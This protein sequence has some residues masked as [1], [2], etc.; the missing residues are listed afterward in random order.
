MNSNKLKR[1]LMLRRM[2]SNSLSLRITHKSPLWVRLTLVFIGLALAAAAGTW[3]Y[4]QGASFAGFNK[5]SIY[6][7]LE[8]LRSE[9]KALLEQREHLNRTSTS[10]QVNLD[11]EKATA[12][13]V[14]VQNQTLEAENAKL[15]EDLRFFET[16]LPTAG[17][18]NTL[19]VRNLQGQLNVTNNQL[20]VRLLVMQSG[21]HV[22]SFVGTLQVNATGIND[23]KPFTWTYPNV[24]AS[25]TADTQLNFLRYQRVELSIPLASFG[26]TL[27]KDAILKSLNIRVVS[28]GALKAQAIGS[29]VQNV[30]GLETTP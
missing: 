25:S 19:S 12:K 18:A 23:G 3:L 30:Q 7:E 28:G 1:K 16:L 9:N 2:R 27:R 14:L 5:N 10:S 21:K 6:Q 13:Q 22:N 29:V 24:A 20:I 4:E 11:V 26:T 15:K 8:H 17:G